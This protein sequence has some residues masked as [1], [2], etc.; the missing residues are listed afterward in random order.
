MSDVIPLPR[1]QAH[2]QHS[3]F[4]N[5]QGSRYSIYL[6]SYSAKQFNFSIDYFVTAIPSCITLHNRHFKQF[7]SAL[8]IYLRPMGI[9]TMRKEDDRLILSHPHPHLVWLSSLILLIHYRLKF[10]NA[11]NQSVSI[12]WSDW[13]IFSSEDPWTRYIVMKNTQLE[14][15]FFGIPSSSQPLQLATLC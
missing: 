4:T 3:A 7:Y 14:L 2:I 9:Q 1:C 5:S 15:S 10:Q 6:E 8:M 11:N 13:L 12:K